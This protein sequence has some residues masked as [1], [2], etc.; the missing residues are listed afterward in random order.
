MIKLIKL[1]EDLKPPPPE[2]IYEPGFE[3]GKDFPHLTTAQEKELLS[4]GQILIPIEDPTRT[5]AS[6][7]VRLPKIKD[8]KRVV[9]DYSNELRVFKSSNDKDLRMLGEELTNKLN[10]VGKLLNTLD[11]VLK[12]YRKDD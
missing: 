6:E 8:M 2:K 4:K 11:S 10:Y 1:L 9:K 5:S 3:P 12:T 7:V